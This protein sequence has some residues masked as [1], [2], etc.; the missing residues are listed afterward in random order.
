MHNSILTFQ[1]LLK[2]FIL[3]ALASFVLLDIMDIGS[4]LSQSQGPYLYKKIE[5]NYIPQNG[6]VVLNIPIKSA[7]TRPFEVMKS[8]AKSIEKKN[9]GISSNGTCVS[10]RMEVTWDYVYDCAEHGFNGSLSITKK[11]GKYNLTPTYDINNGSSDEL[12]PSL[13][14]A[15]LSMYKITGERRYLKY[16]EGTANAIE[17]RM[18]NGK[19]IMRMYSRTRGP[20]DTEPTDLNYYFLASVAELAIYDP[21]YRHLA[22]RVADG[23]ISYGLSK[24]DIPYG[25]IYP[26]GTAAETENG[27]SSNGGREGSISIT[28]VGLL[29]T[30]EATG[31]ATYLN[32]S[33][34]ILSSI[35]KNERT[36]Y[37]LIPRIFDSDTLKVIAND[38]QLYATG[39]FLRAYIYYYYL[40]HDQGI[41]D[42]ILDYST[43][44]YDDYW[45]K[46]TDGHG[47]F[48][49][50]VNVDKGYPTDWTLETNWHKLDMSLI[51]AGE[52]TGKN[53][54]GKVFQDMNTFWLGDGLAY[55][56]HLFRHGTK[57]DGRPGHNRQ[58]LIYSSFRTANYVMLRMLNSGA[59]NPSN[60]TWNDKIWSHINSVQVDHYQEYGYHSNVNVGSLRPDPNYY[61]LSVEPACGEFASLVTLMFNTTPNVEMVWESFPFGD[62]ILEPFP[63]EYSADDLG[64]MRDVVMDYLH[65]EIIFKKIICN[66]EG[67]VHCSQPI[68]EVRRDGQIYTNWHNTNINIS[69]G[70]HEY[71]IIFKRGDFA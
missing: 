33:R 30:Y 13:L 64:F 1:K 51:Y 57:P 18:L 60:C 3:L 11:Y 41:K 10:K 50:R 25:S 7:N 68:E 58:S 39:E 42:I 34:D 55:E 19:N 61:G 63:A 12:Y 54:T 40:T 53:Y 26:N 69:D 15:A 29:R 45:S 23:I 44:A 17:E 67:S 49:Y 31:N 16:A 46:T 52:V 37:N 9:P 6:S 5:I 36:R 59:F 47:Y 22:Q 32:K 35:W 38:T 27:L 28:V 20:G 14:P 66:G 71:A 65:K 21:S 56:N 4:S 70:S 48:V 43:A 8:T 24:N 2:L 62:D